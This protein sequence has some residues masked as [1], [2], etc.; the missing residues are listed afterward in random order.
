M[1]ARHSGEGIVRLPSNV[2]LRL[3]G[4]WLSAFLDIPY[5]KRNG[6]V[7]SHCEL[8]YP[9]YAIFDLRLQKEFV[10]S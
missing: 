5:P 8:V 10:A 3:M 1:S 9:D 7:A 2:G 4:I 6:F